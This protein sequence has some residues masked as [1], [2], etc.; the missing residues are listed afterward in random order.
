MRTMVE[1]TF[2]TTAFAKVGVS[3]DFGG[4][5]FITQLVGTAKARELFF[6]SERITAEEALRLG[7]V[8]WV[9]P[10]ETFETAS[11]A[12]ARQLA[13]GRTLALGYMKDNLNRALVASAIECLDS[14]AASYIACTETQDHKET[15]LAFVEKRPPRFSGR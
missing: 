11:L 13:S 5:Y 4:T 3:G 12:L 7:L 15:A 14:E 2:M 10:A 9:H 6:L 1:G 8:N